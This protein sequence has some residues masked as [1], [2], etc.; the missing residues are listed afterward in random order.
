MF[1][2][3]F[4]AVTFLYFFQLTILTAQQNYLPFIEN[5]D[6]HQGELEL[7][8]DSTAISG[9]E[10]LSV[11][12]NEYGRFRIMPFGGMKNSTHSMLL[13]SRQDN[14]EGTVAVDLSL[15]LEQYK[16]QEVRLSFDAMRIK[17]FSDSLDALFI[18]GSEED[19][20]I[21]IFHWFKL[22][23]LARRKLSFG[24]D[25]ILSNHNQSFSDKVQIRF[26][27]QSRRPSSDQKLLDALVID[28]IK[29]QQV[30]NRN[31]VITDITRLCPGRN[32]LKAI[33][34]NFGEDSIHSAVINWRIDKG[35]WEKSFFQLALPKNGIDTLE[36]GIVE[37]SMHEYQF[38]LVVDSINAQEDESRL[39]TFNQKRFTALSGRYSVG[40][41]QFFND[42]TE[43]YEHLREFGLCGQ[44]ILELSA[45][46]FWGSLRFEAIPNNIAST[47]ISIIGAYNGKTVLID[48]SAGSGFVLSI[49]DW[50]NLSLKRLN[51][52]ANGD[53]HGRVVELLNL[54][55]KL[56]ID[57]CT[58]ENNSPFSPSS[59]SCL[60]IDQREDTCSFSIRNSRL[61]R[62]GSRYN[63]LI[64]ALGDQN[65][66]E[67]Y[68]NYFKGGCRISAS[69][70]LNARANE[71][72]GTVD[73]DNTDT[74]QLHG[75]EI[76]SL[77]EGF[78]YTYYRSIGYLRATN[79][80]I[81]S[82]KVA[83]RIS[84]RITIELHIRHNTCKGNPPLS[85]SH[86]QPILDF[87]NNLMLT[88]SFPAMYIFREGKKD[89]T[90]FDF[91]GNVFYAAGG[92]D[93]LL[94]NLSDHNNRGTYYST[95]EQLNNSGYVNLK[96]NYQKSPALD[97]S[98]R[99]LDDST[100]LGVESIGLKRDIDGNTRCSWAATPGACETEK[101]PFDTVKLE[102]TDSLMMGALYT[103]QPPII[104]G[105]E[106]GYRWEFNNQPVGD[107]SFLMH[108]FKEAGKVD[109]RLIR[110]NCSHTDT[111]Y[112]EMVIYEPN[113]LP[114]SSFYTNKD[115]LS[116]FE[117]IR[118]H[119][120]SKEAD[121][122]YWEISPAFSYPNGISER[123]YYYLEG[124]D[125]NSR[126]PVLY[127]RH[128]AIYRVC[129]EAH[130]SLGSSRVC[131]DSA[132]L[133]NEEKL[134]CQFANNETTSP[135]G[136]LADYGG[137]S[138]SINPGGKYCTYLI[139]PCADETILYFDE[140]YLGSSL[141]RIYDGTDE[142]GIPLHSKRPESADGL[143]GTNL[144]PGRDTFVSTTGSFY[145]VHDMSKFW[146]QTP[147][148]SLRWKVSKQS[149][150]S[151]PKPYFEGPK[152][153]CT[154]KEVSFE[155]LSS[156]KVDRY[157]WVISSPQTNT[158]RISDSSLT[159]TFF[160]PE[161]YTVRLNAENCGGV[162]GYERAF[163]VVD[164]YDKPNAQMLISDTFV[165]PLDTVIL[166]DVSLLDSFECWNSS[167]WEISPSS[168]QLLPSSNLNS[169]TVKVQFLKLGYFDIRLQSFNELGKDEI[170]I[171]KAILVDNVGLNQSVSGV[172]QTYP[173]PVGEHMVIK[174]SNGPSL[175]GDLLIYSADGTAL[176]SQKLR[177]SQEGASIQLPQMSKGIYL[178]RFKPSNQ[179]AVYHSYFVK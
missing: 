1:R 82:D 44:L 5:F 136:R 178:L 61:L 48:T 171:E 57:S 118:L 46:T 10:A 69:S 87:R 32:A 56:T 120:E 160:F 11:S 140:I 92:P 8:E 35:E 73:V 39:D 146:M 164:A 86:D 165:K 60:Y 93:F 162:A 97:S 43:A 24:I 94:D 23:D 175:S 59:A 163:K 88:D 100:F 150:I 16:G 58:I 2:K 52:L 90:S 161:D 34:K 116:T 149:S 147:G 117:P 133:V 139:D 128:P 158:I 177:L 121:S 20:W 99:F 42:L 172:L 27:S 104:T 135:Y 144:N 130:N 151:L 51:I 174:L 170:T 134:M 132:F 50:A 101:P 31:G 62:E 114:L 75:N 55:R 29:V 17:G 138:G 127:L 79:N 119:N 143:T 166:K 77:N 112:T 81:H 148:F 123:N 71:I 113:K 179:N 122:F 125:S 74:V 152:G 12:L 156:G 3:R 15:D 18:R 66:V 107:S 169:R 30:L 137:S 115:V 78:V 84:N 102:L 110:S 70:K 157:E 91:Q 22:P 47:S 14:R 13:D 109:I 111:L 173:N 49:T 36:L 95:I 155:N 41:G 68:N 6:K 33:L 106:T 176:L 25:T 65:E 141:L 7:L 37:M 21:Q 83:M 67:L 105:Q 19:E 28:E 63:L 45:D 72:I 96:G 153:A 159:H 4:L 38:E 145:I 103:F 131:K 64:F 26:S 129:L 167:K 53:S 80:L 76:S 154:V 9:Y 124:T 108:R 98:L 54:H 142:E 40:P 89:T 126:N 168:Y 85:L